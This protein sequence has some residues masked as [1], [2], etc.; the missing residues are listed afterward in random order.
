MGVLEVGD[1]FHVLRW[2]RTFISSVTFLV[3]YLRH[4][5][6]CM[7][8]AILVKFALRAAD[9]SGGPTSSIFPLLLP[10]ITGLFCF[11]QKGQ[12][13]HEFEDDLDWIEA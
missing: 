8:R 11:S 3:A 6:R 9:P 13:D 1:I 2:A 5:H 7:K 4:C 10:V 12:Q